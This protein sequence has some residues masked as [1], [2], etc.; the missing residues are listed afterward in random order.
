MDAA[1]EGHD[2]IVKM[3]IEKG[4]A[5]DVK[6]KVSELLPHCWMCC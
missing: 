6:N 3:L 2:D 5:L 4:A 1:N